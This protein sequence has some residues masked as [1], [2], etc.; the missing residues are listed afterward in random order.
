MN[1]DVD[2]RT[3]SE[4]DEMEMMADTSI[5]QSPS[6]ELNEASDLTTFIEATFKKWECNK[7]VASKKNRETCGCGQ[8]KEVH[9]N[10]LDLVGTWNKDVHSTT[11]KTNAF[12]EVKFLGFGPEDDLKPY[13]RLA[14]NTAY[15]DVWTLLKDYWNVKPPTLIISVT[16]GNK[17]FHLSRKMEQAFQDGLVNAASSTGAWITT[18][19]HNAGVAKVV[20]KAVGFYRMANVA[21]K[22]ITCLG[23]LSWGYVD[24]KE[25]LVNEQG[26]GKFPA[27]YNFED[28]QPVTDLKSEAPLQPNHSHFLFIDDGVD[29]KYGGEGFRAGVEMHISQRVST[30]GEKCPVVRL[31][32][33]GGVNTLTGAAEAIKNDIPCVFFKGTG[34][35][36]DFIS[37]AYRLTAAYS[38]EEETGFPDNFDELIS[39]DT[40]HFLIQCKSDRS[41]EKVYAEVRTI[42]SK[43]L[44]VN[45]FDFTSGDS[46]D[47]EF[48]ILNALL[49]AYRSDVNTQASLAL[50]WNRCDLAR[51]E[52]FSTEK[53][54]QWL[55]IPMHEHMTKALVQNKVDF[56]QLFLDKGVDVKNL[57]TYTKLAEIWSKSL[58][59]PSSPA[60][61]LIKAKLRID[62]AMVIEGN[63]AGKVKTKSFLKAIGNMLASELGFRCLNPYDGEA[64]IVFD[65]DAL[66]DGQHRFLNPEKELFLWAVCFNRAELASLFWQAGNDH[67]AL[68]LGGASVLLSFSKVAYILD[69]TDQAAALEE[70]ARKLEE[71]ASGVLTECNNNNRMNTAKTLVRNI[72][73][74]GHNVTALSV[75]NVGKHMHFMENSACQSFLSNVWKGHL[76]TYTEMWRIIVA[77]FFPFVIL[78]MRFRVGHVR[79]DT[80][81]RKDEGVH[82][83][84][85]KESPVGIL[86]AAYYFYTSPIVKFIF[87]VI[88]MLVLF[89]IFAY[90]VCIDLLPWE[91]KDH[92]VPRSHVIEFIVWAWMA[93]LVAEEL[94][95]IIGNQ[96]QSWRSKIV[97]WISDFWNQL[98]VAIYLLLLISV[99]LRFALTG[100]AFFYARVTYVF[101]LSTMLV[102]FSNNMYVHPDLGPK[103]IM[104]GKM[105]NDLVFFLALLVIFIA[106]YGI[107]SQALLFPNALP[108]AKI[109]KQ[110]FYY[111][112]WTMNGEFDLDLAEGSLSDGTPCSTNRTVL[113]NDPGIVQCPTSTWVVP[114][115][116]CIYVLIVN[117]LLLNLLIAVFSYTFQQ[118]QEQSNRVWRFTLYSFIEE[119]YNRP[120][121]APPFVVFS[122]L[123]LIVRGIYHRYR[124][125]RPT[126]AFYVMCSEEET[127]RLR[128]FERYAVNVYN[129]KQRKEDEEKIG[130]QIGT[131][132]EKI[133]A[134]M[135][136]LKEDIGSKTDVET[137]GTLQAAV[138]ELRAEVSGQR[139][140]IDQQTQLLRD[141]LSRMS[142]GVDPKPRKESDV[143]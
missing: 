89:V 122:H 116:L 131:A 43:R 85:T 140:R 15:E 10:I 113:A 50:A 106:S 38:S 124:G 16:G 96:V 18:T 74:F 88:S 14:D 3:F 99:I 56:V 11:S 123:F 48:A 58:D 130:S 39:H 87:Y 115:A 42:L 5:S 64:R 142:G 6:D 20:G 94:R 80:K 136:Q 103:V 1:N 51:E 9:K 66:K 27:I 33:E 84:L 34:R 141:I 97:D 129:F 23:C 107:S 143:E 75:S 30:K 95:Q 90:F 35:T 67:I 135:T 53:R 121:L 114:L 93:T 83:P 46:A 8:P 86:K 49:K 92:I 41:K 112:Y 63:L 125:E 127:A 55:T 100:E 31:V 45:V 44:L 26:G 54:L 111:P 79:D 4:R 118:I 78:S 36:A 68:A 139:V 25:A 120:V 47:V 12:G 105:L 133:V 101:C 62:Y 109:F 137:I 138:N 102:R 72:P 22:Q 40:A 98:D 17:S 32:L 29:K 132:G 52:I 126:T 117:V 128:S 70:H 2:Y 69:M 91:D 81:S 28:C 60:A 24:N 110:I 37:N 82:S 104:I 77:V 71:K 134:E 21:D 57:L 73:E 76:A 7:F 59:I 119:N 13:I 19:G 108:Q 61:T 65:Q